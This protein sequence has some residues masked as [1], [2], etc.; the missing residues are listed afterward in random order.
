MRVA[1]IVRSFFRREA[2]AEISLFDGSG[3]IFLCAAAAWYLH[4]Y[5]HSVW[6]PG[7][8]KNDVYT[9]LAGADQM[10]YLNGAIDLAHGELK[11]NAYWIG[12]LALG[13]PFHYLLPR[14][15]FLIPDLF[16][17]LVMLGAFFASCRHVMSRAE[18][19]LLVAF[20]VVFA[21]DV[22][23]ER[24]LVV[25]WN[26]MPAYAA[27]YLSAYLMVFAR[28]SLPRFAV[29]AA[30]TSF[31]LLARPNEL[32]ALAPL[33]LVAALLWRD[34]RKWRALG[35]FLGAVTSAAAVIVSIN[36]YLYGAPVSPYVTAE[37]GHFSYD[38]PLLKFY[39]LF[40]DGTFLTGA[41][42]MPIGSRPHQILERFPYLLL[43]GPGVLSLLRV[44]G[45]AVWG[46]YLAILLTLGFYLSY[47]V[48]NSPAF[49]WMY[50]SFHYYWW[51]MPWLIFFTYLSFRQAPLTLARPVYVAALLMPVVLAA[52]VGFKSVEVAASDDPGSPLVLT[53]SYQDETFHATVTMQR[54][55]GPIEDMRLFFQKAPDGFGSTA[56]ANHK[57]GMT[58]NG[59]TLSEPVDYYMSQQGTGPYDVSLIFRAKR[60]HTGDTIAFTYYKT[61]ELTLRRVAL[62]HAESSPG[63]GLRRWLTP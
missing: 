17:V 31:A 8:P 14:H 2:P 19:W 50:T 22:L 58:L 47:D 49:S 13:A 12:Y 53:T 27:I 23:R 48:V 56:E 7:D 6:V 57:F 32:I 54:D 29:A 45:P 33:F 34:P 26:T 51:M 3:L 42:I 28:P 35:L 16:L 41:S 39:Q 43:M 20:A 1:P 52:G 10:R 37:R 36:F 63:A 46:L 5:F 24:C 40:C 62:M 55:V 15:T 4:T 59:A 30:A 38:H 44:C 11:P 60:I 61:G 18:A 25:P 9:W 21:D